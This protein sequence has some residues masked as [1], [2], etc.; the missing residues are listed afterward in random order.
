MEKR[1]IGGGE[2]GYSANSTPIQTKLQRPSFTS[3]N[4][5]SSQ[6]QSQSLSQ[7]QQILITTPLK[8]NS[9]FNERNLIDKLNSPQELEKLLLKYEKSLNV[10]KSE[11]IE[12]KKA[13]LLRQN[14][15]V[16]QIQEEER[17]EE[18]EERE[19]EEN[20]NDKNEKEEILKTTNVISIQE[21]INHQNHNP[22][23]PIRSFPSLP[24]STSSPFSSSSLNQSL[25][26]EYVDD[27][28]ISTPPTTPLVTLSLLFLSLI[29]FSYFFSF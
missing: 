27:S 5:S 2:N 10:R 24:N 16:F 20:E 19:V 1:K 13:N 3:P 29:S 9:H 12:L 23:S 22:I 7:S 28:I 21:T 17:E 11:A 18:R 4:I 15:N 25:L 14:E 26:S 6:S 8:E